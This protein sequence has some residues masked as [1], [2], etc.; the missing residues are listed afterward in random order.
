MKILKNFL[1]NNDSKPTPLQKTVETVQSV[2]EE[3]DSEK[4]IARK[5]AI[6]VALKEIQENKDMPAGK[7]MQMLQEK[8]SLTDEDLVTII[9]QL[10]DVKSEK[11]TIAAVQSTSLSPENITSIVKEADISLDTAEKIVNEI[12]NEA[13]QKEQQA[14]IAA[15]REQ[16][17]LSKLSEIHKKCDSIEDPKLVEFIEKLDIKD[18]TTDINKKLMAI[19]SKRTALDCMKFGGPRLPTLTRILPA[20]DMFEADLPFLAFSDYKALKVK[21]DDDDKKYT[22][23]TDSTKKL[24]RAKILEEIA[25]KTAE[26]YDSTGNFFLPQTEKFK[27]LSNDDIHLFEKT[28]KTYSKDFDKSAGRRLR[29]QLSGEAATELHDLNRMLEKMNPAARD[30][31]LQKIVALLQNDLLTNKSSKMNNELSNTLEEIELAIRKLPA[32]SQLLAAQTILD[33]LNQRNE[34]TLLL[35]NAKKSTAPSHQDDDEER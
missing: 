7:F 31:A 34:A 12:D 8:T 26:T 14:I 5:K 2:I 28:V 9:T 11:A 29:R 18:Y 30:L 21:F 20:E 13:I 22:E 35:K 33:T 1:K 25:K 17:I 10:P 3:T 23:F 27:K 16:Q 32:K 15:E 19:I 4:E 6:E 24:I